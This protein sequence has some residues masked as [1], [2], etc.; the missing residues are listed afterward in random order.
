MLAGFFWAFSD[1][2]SAGLQVARRRFLA[3]CD[4]RFLKC[5]LRGESARWFVSRLWLEIAVY[6]AV[7]IHR[8]KRVWRLGE[9][10]RSLRRRRPGR[11][12]FQ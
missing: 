3:A 5:L 10:R 9:F 11:Q 8:R 4:S 12:G 1:M 7:R 6:G 2:E